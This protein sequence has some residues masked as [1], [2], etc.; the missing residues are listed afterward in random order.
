MINALQFLC[1]AETRKVDKKSSKPK[2]KVKTKQ[3][4]EK[5]GQLYEIS[6]FVLLLFI[7]IAIIS[8]LGARDISLSLFH[9]LGKILYNKSMKY[10]ICSA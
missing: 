3:D 10:Y 2:A 9:A 1:V 4:K 5:K 8:S 7:L 6:T